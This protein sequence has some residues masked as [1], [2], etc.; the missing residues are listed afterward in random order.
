MVRD[1]PTGPYGPMYRKVIPKSKSGLVFTKYGKE[2][3]QLAQIYKFGQVIAAQ[4]I[5]DGFSLKQ[6]AIF[7]EF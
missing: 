1:S 3:H 7:G 6:M 5:N 2:R 4:M